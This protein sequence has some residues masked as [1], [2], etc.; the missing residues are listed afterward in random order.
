M[1]SD[2]PV[3]P[4]TESVDW[5]QYNDTDVKGWPTADNP[6]AQ[7]AAFNIPDNEQVLLGLW[8]QSAQ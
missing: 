4:V 2:V 1:I 3:I 5:F 8:S 6:Y 7:P